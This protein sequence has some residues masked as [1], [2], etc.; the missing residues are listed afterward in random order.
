MDIWKA[1][2]QLSIQLYLE[3]AA[4]EIVPPTTPE[5]IAEAMEMVEL[6]P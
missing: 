2:L 6:I 3:D 4:L 1:G 5:M